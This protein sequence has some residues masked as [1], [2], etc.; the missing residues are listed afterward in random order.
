MKR[1]ILSIILTLAL[2]L[3]LLPT[4]ALA[5][6]ACENHSEACVEAVQT[7][8]NAL[9]DMAE[10]D[11]SN[12][13]TVIAAME[14]IDDAKAHLSDEERNRIDFRKY[15]DAAFVLSTP[16]G[17]FGFMATKRY[18]AGVDG[19]VP[20]FQF[21]DVVSGQPAQLTA[22]E[23]E[24]PQQEQTETHSHRVCGDIDCEHGGHS[25]QVTYTEVDKNSPLS[26]TISAGSYYLADDVEVS[27][28]ITIKEEVELCLNGNQLK[29]AEGQTGSLFLIQQGGKLTLCDCSGDNS[30]ELV[31]NQTV[32]NDNYGGGSAVTVVSGVF[33]MY[34]G[35]I[36]NTKADDGGGV[37]V[38]SNGTFILNGGVI[39]GNHSTNSGGGV[40][41]T[42][43]GTFTVNGGVISGNTGY[44]SSGA[45]VKSSNVYIDGHAPFT[46]GTSLRKRTLIYVDH[47]KDT[48]FTNEDVDPAAVE[49]FQS[50]N[51]DLFVVI[52]A[53]GALKVVDSQTL[54]KQTHKVC[55]A[56]DCE[57][58]CEGHTLHIEN[59][60]YTGLVSLDN[61]ELSGGNYCLF[62]DLEVIDPLTITGEVN[63]CLNGHTLSLA[64]G[65]EGSLL[66]IKQDE[67]S[68]GTLT[69]C[70]CK[71][72]GKLVGNDDGGSVVTVAP[73]GTF[74]MYSGTITGAKATSGG[75][76]YVGVENSES[77]SEGNS[78]TF[79]MYGGSI[80][81]NTA[82]NGGGVYL[83]DGTFNMYDGTI[84]GNTAESNGGGV[85]AEKGTFIMHGGSISNNKAQ[86]GGGVYMFN[87]E[88]GTPPVFSMD[89]GTISGN[90]AAYDGGGVFAGTGSMFML[91]DQA[92]I[93]ENT[94]SRNGGGVHIAG[95]QFIMDNGTIIDNTSES[96]G[97]GVYLNDGTFTMYSG[98]IS[99][100]EAQRGGGVAAVGGTFTIYDGTISGNTA[101]NT[102]GGVYVDPGTN[103][104]FTVNGGIISDNKKSSGRFSNVYVEGGAPFTVGVSL[105]DDTKI[106][107]DHGIGA[108][109]TNAGL[110]EGAET[111]FISSDTDILEVVQRD[112]TALEIKLRDDRSPADH[113][114]ASCGTSGTNCG[115]DS[116][117]AVEKYTPWTVGG[118][119]ALE[120]N[121][122]LLADLQVA[123]TVTINKP[124][125]LCLNGHELLLKSGRFQIEEGGAL[126]LCDCTGGGRI[127]GALSNNGTLYVYG[128][129]L[130]EI[131]LGNRGKVYLAADAKFADDQLTISFTGSEQI[132]ADPA[133]LS[134]QKMALCLDE[135]VSAVPSG[136]IVTAWKADGDGGDASFTSV[137]CFTLVRPEKYKLELKEDGVVLSEAGSSSSGGGTP[138]G[139]PSSGDGGGGGSYTPPSQPVTVPISGEDNTIYVGASVKGDT[140]TIDKVDLSHLDEVIGDHV[141]DVGT[142][143]ID[144]SDLKS[145]EPITTVELPANV[146]K[147]IAAAVND[148]AN[149]AHSLEIVLANGLS[150]EFDAVALGEK[151]AQADGPDITIS[152]QN[153]KDAKPNQKQEA[154]LKGRPA[155]DITVTSGGEHISDI[156][157]K[158]TVHAPYELQNGEHPRGIV[159]WYVDED[160]KR[161]RCETSYDPVK[162]RVN[163][164]TD[165]LS[166]YMID[167]DESAINPFTDISEEAYYYD[168]VLWALDKGITGGT[169]ATTFSPDASCTR[170][171]MATFLWRA[172]G[173]PEPAGGTNPF[174]D[175]K[176]DAYY[177]KAVQWVYEQGITAG[178]SATTFSPDAP[179]TR[180]QMATFIYRTEQAKGGGFTGT[181]MFHVPFTDTPEW[182]FEA[183]AWCYM[184]GITQ[185]TGDGTTFSPD[186]DCTRGQM[187]TFLYRY[188][189]K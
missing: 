143:T 182:A 105:A 110:P 138:G 114:H 29:L 27:S 188:F 1:R 13:D 129:T 66:R 128:G 59:V 165:H 53:D 83:N 30:G 109:F 52:T 131:A 54:P 176:A 120:G 45:L 153:S 75:G 21:I 137:D 69:L 150:I 62:R 106:Y 100:N 9:P 22:L 119:S 142:V 134:T 18:E 140:A 90:T 32:G 124:V 172:A 44:D 168:S 67:N 15:S 152:I 86:S 185:G 17:C 71:G 164:K 43:N 139:R 160:G 72:G 133:L 171:Q 146:V 130:T 28:A 16:E 117:H 24:P 47:P 177:A 70:D 19:P 147:K 49:Y 148:P 158:I 48:V 186:V 74:N 8:V 91:R 55:G 79:N 12:K 23:A 103:T 127:I 7:L 151:V 170:A 169:T 95:G 102:G 26:G 38:N 98:T 167:Y 101:A 175:V 68:K 113:E 181:W 93:T 123:Q 60:T 121:C 94:S 85:Y 76:V 125:N 99:D 57:K 33:D 157:G 104:T 112:D 155:Y 149:D 14:E 135:S 118:V 122:Y 189:G 36:C 87:D 35:T 144:F 183:I 174:T 82:E 126:T 132:Y 116:A 51:K 161:E 39:S 5:A 163:W 88:G 63:L 50:S 46:V 89:G 141:E 40:Y 179:C 108:V 41:V 58:D 97:G 178:T 34:G 25:S 180:A 184:K 162:K 56:A 65:V 173:S 2:C 84:G 159:V 115:H 20:T 107:V 80:S 92:A 61:T 6:A 42:S 10:I 37:Y 11:A 145:R 31:G 77:S 96:N 166:L 136:A 3:G 78:G 81:G 73:K 111:Y 154:A 187:V 4:A 156:G 64:D